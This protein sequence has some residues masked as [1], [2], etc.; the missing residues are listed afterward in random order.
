MFTEDFYPTPTE[1][2][3]M[4]Q[5]DCSGKL[6]LEPHAGSGNIV[7]WLG[8]HGAQEVFSYE[9]HEALAKIVKEESTYLGRDFLKATAED[10]SHVDL[11]VMNPPFSCADSHINHAFEIAPAGCEI[12]A[13]VNTETI[14]N[15]FTRN[16]NRLVH[17]INESGFKERLG[18]VFTAA[19]RKTKVDVTL[20]KLFK[21]G[22]REGLDYSEFFLEE[23]EEELISGP[24]IMRYNEIRAVVN[25]YVG[26]VKVF[27]SIGKGMESLGGI[28]KQ[29]GVESPKLKVDYNEELIG[30]DQYMK[31]LQKKMWK[32]IF[33]QMKLEKYVTSGVM[34]DINK[35]VEVQTK[36][37]FTMRNIYRML[38]V[39]YGTREN[40]LNEAL[41]E[42]VDKFTK[43]SHE[44]RYM[45]EGWKTNSGY[46][47]NEKFIIS[48]AVEPAYGSDYELRLLY[49]GSYKS[50][51]DLTKVLCNLTATDYDSIGSLW[52][53]FHQNK[54]YR[55]EWYDWGFFEIKAFKKGSMHL[56]FKNE[57]DWF[58]LNQ[59][60]GKL[61]GFVLHEKQAA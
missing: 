38:E 9:K 8:E 56:K 35:F 39:I 12:I 47:L 34:E 29:Y 4:M 13:I 28:T 16:R 18:C 57:R 32:H 45:V 17:R 10:I 11:I 48:W 51:D 54:I 24:G 46:M 22:T 25:S 15:G 40:K 60:Y 26:A 27:E 58:L 6:V 21:P 5:I 42:A 44:N 52:D 41:V 7:R 20:V 36:V 19:E 43:H 31:F 50:V 55:G 14:E 3:N 2:I 59:H 53:F 37:P 23:D 30:K 49:Q 33:R 61:K 1:V